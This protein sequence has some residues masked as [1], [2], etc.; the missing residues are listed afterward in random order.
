MIKNTTKDKL[1]DSELERIRLK[2]FEQV[3]ELEQE[4]VQAVKIPL[5]NGRTKIFWA[6]RARKQAPIIVSEF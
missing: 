4:H 3:R 5:D 2:Y 1:S 6:H